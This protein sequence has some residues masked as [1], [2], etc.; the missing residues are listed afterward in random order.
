MV[1]GP[2]RTITTSYSIF[3]QAEVKDPITF[4]PAPV[5]TT[6]GVAYAYNEIGIQTEADG[7]AILHDE[8][9]SNLV[10][11]DPLFL[12][13]LGGSNGGPPTV[14]LTISDFFKL[15]G[16]ITR[17]HFCAGA[18]FPSEPTILPLY[19]THQRPERDRCA[20]A[21]LS[22]SL[23]AAALPRSGHGFCSA[24]A[25]LAGACLQISRFPDSYALWPWFFR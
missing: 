24:I 12:L 22:R 18:S 8:F 20:N 10:T 14:D 4:D 17:S 11:Q 3:A 16:S 19:P 23:Q 15:Q 1:A 5:P 21:L 13:D 25:Y 9:A 6:I 7:I 2:A